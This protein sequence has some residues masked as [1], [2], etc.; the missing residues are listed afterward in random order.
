MDGEGSPQ[1]LLRV[2]HPSKTHPGEGSERAEGVP[3]APPW[4]S[5]GGGVTGRWTVLA[6]SEPAVF[7]LFKQH[8]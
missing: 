1:V 8:R 7:S 3:G 6:T 2:G 4:P 5:M